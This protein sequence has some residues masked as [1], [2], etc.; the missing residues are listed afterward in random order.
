MS[1]S[2]RK[3]IQLKRQRTSPLANRLPISPMIRLRSSMPSRCSVKY[4]DIMN[5]CAVRF[6]NMKRDVGSDKGALD[7]APYETRC[8][9]GL[10]EP[11]RCQ[12][13]SM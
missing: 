11:A 2:V 4:E 13:K 3:A 6:L 9:F 5:P 1:I 10:M 12:M 8:A 7:I